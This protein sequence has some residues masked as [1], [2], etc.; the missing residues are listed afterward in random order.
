MD[1][2]IAEEA[3]NEVVTQI[4]MIDWAHIT[5]ICEHHGSRYKMNAL[6]YI[7]L[8]GKD[9]LRLRKYYGHLPQRFVISNIEGAV[10]W[11]ECYASACYWVLESDHK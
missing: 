8:T 6:P 7:L 4:D 2:I 9:E 3:A 1:H 5:I 10:N 11:K